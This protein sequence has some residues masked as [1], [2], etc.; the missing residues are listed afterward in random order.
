[1]I[2]LKSARD[3]ERMRRAGRIVAEVLQILAS[4]TEPGVTT[5]DLDVIADR[6]IRTRGGVPISR[7]ITDTRLACVSPSIRRWCTAYRGS[8]W[9]GPGTSSALI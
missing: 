8:A 4:A 1:M 2:E 9:F 5:H 3:R 6:E 7:D